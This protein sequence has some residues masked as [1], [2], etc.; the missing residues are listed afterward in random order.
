[1]SKQGLYANQ[2]GGMLETVVVSVLESKG[3]QL[4]SYKD[5]RVSPDSSEELLIKNMPFT[6]IYGHPGMTEFLLKSK[7]YN[8][9]MRIECKWQ[10]VA[11][12]VDEKFPYLYLNCIEAMPENDILILVDG[13]G[14]KKGSLQWLKDACKNKLYVSDRNKF[15]NIQVMST[16]EFI[17]WA[18]VTFR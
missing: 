3:F 5:Y 17:K 12:S 18:N 8:L 14:A 13:T 7:K 9:Q 2:F 11:G 1:M 15:K 10:Q 16:T 6:T 4:I